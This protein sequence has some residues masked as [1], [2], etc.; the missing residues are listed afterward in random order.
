MRGDIQA[1]L[2]RKMMHGQFYIAAYGSIIFICTATLYEFRGYNF[3]F[4]LRGDRLTFFT[5]M[6]QTQK[7]AFWIGYKISFIKTGDCLLHIQ[8]WTDLKLWS[9]KIHLLKNQLVY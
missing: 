8:R 5:F 7:Y 1:Y 2:N 4:C 3:P 6:H 9:S